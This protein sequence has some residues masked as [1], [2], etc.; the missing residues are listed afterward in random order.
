[1]SPQNLSLEARDI[2]EIGAQLFFLN[3]KFSEALSFRK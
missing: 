2:V 3:F 1:M